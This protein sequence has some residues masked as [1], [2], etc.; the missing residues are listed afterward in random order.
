MNEV[1]RDWSDLGVLVTG[2]AS[3][4]G[5]AVTEKFANSGSKVAALDINGD[6]LEAS[7]RPLLGSKKDVRGFACD[8]TLESSVQR[9]T[10]H[11]AQWLSKI[12]TLVHCA[13]VG[14]YAPFLDLS[15][16]DWERAMQVNVL[17]VA[18]L[19]RH[20]LPSMIARGR[21][22]III[23]GSRRGSEPNL[24]TSSYSASKAAVAAFA[25]A[26]GLE[27][28]DKG[29]HVCLLAPG[30]VLTSFGDVSVEKKDARFLNSESVAEAVLYIARHR[31]NAW[32][33]EMT[34]LPL[35]L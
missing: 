8:V 22:Q 9:S 20:I 6:A 11:I 17:G 18:R 10:T 5:R 19:T 14:R 35:G 34:L 24:G 23:V 7:L 12:D 27:V 15:E 26:L 33:R 13:G 2:A 25:R 3:G 4:I 29:I 31:N 28:S 30:G 32:L 1:S 21:G 16:Q